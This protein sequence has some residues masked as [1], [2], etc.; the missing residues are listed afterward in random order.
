MYCMNE[1][2]VIIKPVT[3]SNWRDF[4]SL[5]ESRGAPSWCWCMVWRLTKEERKERGRENR[6][7]CMKGRIQSKVPVGILAYTADKPVAWCSVAP[8]GSHRNLGGDESLG[9][10]WS[11]T[12]FFIK[13]E[14]RGRNMVSTLIEAAVQYAGDNGARYVEAYPVETDS[15][16]YRYMGF[17]SSF[18]KAGFNFVKMAGTKRH[19][20]IR[21]L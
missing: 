20:M 6:K 9:D 19:V 7:K 4:E 11:I 18:E 5:F 3:D 8:R 2:D 1:S 10:V 14:F 12:C 16:S 17:I 15:Q 13:R 21:K